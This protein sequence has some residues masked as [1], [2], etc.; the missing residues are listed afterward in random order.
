MGESMMSKYT[1][2]FGG[3][4]KGQSVASLRLYAV[5]FV[6]VGVTF[7]IGLR[8]LGGLSSNIEGEKAQTG[9]DAAINAILTFTQWLGLI[10]LIIVAGII[11][12]HVTGFGRSA[13]GGNRGR[14]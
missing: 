2:M 7:A 12:R 6:V 1:N 5:L 4:R 10:A 13:S 9:I 8:I 3:S 14:A 11:I